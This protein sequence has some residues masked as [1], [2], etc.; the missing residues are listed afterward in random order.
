MADEGGPWEP[1]Q[2]QE[3]RTPVQRGRLLIWIG[4]VATLGGVVWLLMKLFPGQSR[5][6]LAWLFRGVV[7]LAILSTGILTADQIRWGEKARHAAIWLGIAAVLVLGFSYRDEL[8]G[9]GLRVR[10]EFASSY[11][12][13]SGAHELV[14][15]QGDDGGFHVMA[16]VNGRP[17]RFL[18]DTGATDTVLSPDDARRLGVDTATL[19]FD[20]VA[21]TANGA[22][23]GARFMVDELAVGRIR[24]TDVPVLINR[25][26]MSASLLGLT[27]LQRLESFQVKG[28]KLYMTWRG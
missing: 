11:P 12:V 13:A 24:F 23:Y 3:A 4:L 19:K 14:V 21:E 6:D 10:S 20:Q 26:P 1:E 27:F 2:H 17:V 15:T 28:Q 18:I 25:A 16:Q 9:V 7:L 22:G 5:D 8:Q